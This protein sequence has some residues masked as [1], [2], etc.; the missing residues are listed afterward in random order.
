[1]SHHTSHLVSHLSGH[2]QPQKAPA[3]TGQP[4]G[5]RPASHAEI[6]SRAYDKY[7]AR[8]RVDGFD[9]DDWI[10]AS[11]ELTG[12]TSRTSGSPSLSPTL[13]SS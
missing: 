10:D 3:P 4:A 12:D 5:A 11:H 1:M 7:E 13:P 6:A 2:V 9:L 8:G